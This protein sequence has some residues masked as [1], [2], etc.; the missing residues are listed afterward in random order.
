MLCSLFLILPHTIHPASLKGKYD[1][2]V[3]HM[4]KPKLRGSTVCLWS[5][6]SQQP[7][8]AW[9][10]YPSIWPRSLC[11]F[12]SNTMCFAHS[13]NYINISWV[14]AT[15]LNSS[16][17]TVGD[18]GCWAPVQGGFHTRCAEDVGTR[19][20]LLNIKESPE[21]LM[22]RRL[23]FMQVLNLCFFEQHHWGKERGYHSLIL[24]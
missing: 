8:Q 11:S 23:S 7:I 14:I 5:E 22:V 12:S 2:P 13:G 24:K 19:R 6:T 4:R 16:F 1:H 15:N 10:R 20:S 9:D 3:S 17:K 18:P 21:T